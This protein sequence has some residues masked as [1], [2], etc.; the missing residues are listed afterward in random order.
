MSLF[1]GDSMFSQHLENA[2]AEAI[3]GHNLKNA[4][5]LID[6][7]NED[8]KSSLL[9]LNDKDEN[10]LH[11]ALKIKATDIFELIYG[12]IKD[13]SITEKKK[14][15][16]KSCLS[17]LDSKGNSLFGLALRLDDKKIA[18]TLFNDFEQ[19]YSFDEGI[20]VF[21][22]ANN[23]GNTPLH[24]A[25]AH[26]SKSFKF[27]LGKIN[28]ANGSGDKS[29][30]DLSETR[31]HSAFF[32]SKNPPKAAKDLKPVDPRLNEIN[33]QGNSP[34]HLTASKGNITNT[35]LL[36]NAG[37]S[38]FLKNNEGETAADLL[39]KPIDEK[40]ASILPQVFAALNPTIK[41]D[42]L[43]YYRNK[44]KASPEDEQLKKLYFTLA[45]MISLVVLTNAHLEFNK[46]VPI[47]T[48][49]P[50]RALFLEEIPDS[51]RQNTFKAES[52]QGFVREKNEFTQDMKKQLNKEALIDL[53]IDL[54]RS[55]EG[56]Q[57]RCTAL[58]EAPGFNTT[59]NNS[60][61]KKWANN[62][63][64]VFNTFVKTLFVG[65][66]LGFG[67]VLIL[68]FG[69]GLIALGLWALPVF[70]AAGVF[71][72]TLLG[73]LVTNLFSAVV[74]GIDSFYQM[75]SNNPVALPLSVTDTLNQIETLSSTA[76]WPETVTSPLERLIGQIKAKEEVDVDEVAVLKD[77]THYLID[78]L[79][80]VNFLVV[81]AVKKDLPQE[82]VISDNKEYDEESSLLDAARFKF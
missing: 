79:N 12:T 8:K 62:D 60:A 77:F 41:Q 70:L 74:K 72:G 81:N 34:L 50:A 21:F 63:E 19:T 22:K 35:V 29:N 17:K 1:L 18:T 20:V 78:D 66:F 6:L 36:I 9:S 68:L 39:E 67:L 73:G 25:A 65:A 30:Q 52:E 24:L 80:T 26:E 38:L 42:L 27:I 55:L 28:Q 3:T 37:A 7:I 13:G 43:V 31:I 61:L 59:F 15:K 14:A 57:T 23:E 40:S 45:G 46:E 2:L 54:E 64:A 53:L 71:V 47:K 33:A 16:A 11:L 49:L 69:A 44:L 75:S 5:R 58:N 4:T 82:R 51:Y 48:G 76:N 10:F 32:A 56:V